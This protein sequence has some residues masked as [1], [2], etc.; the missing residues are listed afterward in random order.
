[1]NLTSHNSTHNA[2]NPTSSSSSSSSSLSMEFEFNPKEILQMP[3]AWHLASCLITTTVGGMYIAGTFKVFGQTKFSNE[4]FLS[5]ISSIASIFNSLGRIFWGSLADQL[6]P[7]RTLII[8][9]ILFSMIIATYPSTANIGEWVFGLW[10]FL[11][12][13]FEGANF[14]LY[15]PMTV[16]LFGSKYSASNYGLI[17]SSYSFFTVLNIFVL[18]D[19][20]VPFATAAL[21]MGALTFIGFL[22]LLLLQLHIRIT[23]KQSGE[24][25]LG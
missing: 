24:C 21:M 8:M 25:K 6:G 14:V 23:K 4:A 12:F 17:F 16:L 3:L 22:N 20:D 19:T 10:T 5:T 11:I 2:L 15:V 7:L 13:F 1:V 9:S 18:S